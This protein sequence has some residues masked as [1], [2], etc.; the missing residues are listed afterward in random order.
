MWKLC[1]AAGLTKLISRLSKGGLYE[2]ALE[3][4]F[5]LPELHIQYDCTIINAALSAC[6]R[7]TSVHRRTR[8]QYQLASIVHW[9]FP[10]GWVRLLITSCKSKIASRLALKH[11][12]RIKCRNF[13]QDYRLDAFWMMCTVVVPESQFRRFCFS[14]RAQLAQYWVGQNQ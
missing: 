9:S 3:L 4:F 13:R 8:Y 14:C 6:G 10:R 1:D 7:G 2:K 11:H 12:S 5:I